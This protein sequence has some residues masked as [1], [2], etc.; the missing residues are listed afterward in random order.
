VDIYILTIIVSIKVTINDWKTIAMNPTHIHMYCFN[1]YVCSTGTSSSPSI[2]YFVK[3]CLHQQWVFVFMT[4]FCAFLT[5]NCLH[6]HICWFL[7]FIRH[8]FYLNP[9]NNTTFYCLGF[10]QHK[11]IVN[12]MTLFTTYYCICPLIALPSMMQPKE[13][14]P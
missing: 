11:K 2:V 14:T 8:T 3:R 12:Q 5:A 6:L 9:L 7:L 10:Q 1:V 4:T 13:W